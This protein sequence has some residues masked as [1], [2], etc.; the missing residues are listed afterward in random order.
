MGRNSLKIWR[1]LIAV[2]LVSRN[3]SAIIDSKAWNFLIRM[4][5]IQKESDKTHWKIILKEREGGL[6]SEDGKHPTSSIWYLKVF[7]FVLSVSFENHGQEV[8][9]KWEVTG[10]AQKLLIRSI[11]VQILSGVFFKW[12]RNRISTNR[13]DLS[14][15]RILYRMAHTEYPTLNTREV[16]QRDEAVACRGM[17]EWLV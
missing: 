10:Q 2:S 13:E 4:S 8:H 14:V 11:D 6:V 15:S 7:T 3:T 17:I 1:Q 16:L 9:E 12:V 5:F